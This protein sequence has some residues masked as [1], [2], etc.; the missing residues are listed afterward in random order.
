MTSPAGV[1][2]LVRRTHEDRVLHVLREH[3]A[4]TRAE[5]ADRIGL[6]RTT[7]SEI[8]ASL[9]SRGLIAVDRSAAPIAGRGRPAQTLRLDPVAGLYLGVDFRH[10]A[11]QVV[12]ANAAREIIASDGLAYSDPAEASDQRPD[13][14]QRSR[15]AFDLIDRM[16]T[17]GGVHLRGVLG[18]A[19]GLP[20]PFPPRIPRPHDAPIA[21]ARRELADTVRSEFAQRF[22]I[23]VVLDNNTRLAALAEAAW[24]PSEAVADLLYV[25]LSDGVGGGLVVDGR[26]VAG[27]TGFAGELGHLR[28]AGADGE[29][30]CGKRGCLE[31]VAS[32]HAVLVAC[33]QAGVA[34]ESLDE[35]ESAAAKGDPSV[36]AV[37]RAVGSAVGQVLGSLAVALN[38][39]EIV[40][41]GEVALAS[42]VLID[43]IVETVTYELLPVGRYGPRIRRTSLRHEAGAIGGI[44][45]LLRRTPVLAGYPTLTD[46]A[47]PEGRTP[48]EKMNAPLAPT[49]GSR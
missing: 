37:L 38:P 39:R 27:S 28:V 48:R 35:V 10:R 44:I 20:G 43:Q 4:L 24:R 32:I 33:A 19:V 36:L 34:V 14:V 11:V 6:S 17:A 31:T 8:T 40:I 2:A 47:L 16:A 46:P 25:R 12:I 9:L 42:D 3:G 30:R 13:W 1:H 29:C 22:G 5:L 45:A 21:E 26:L 7:L 49:G 15:V 41:G 18:I 23:D